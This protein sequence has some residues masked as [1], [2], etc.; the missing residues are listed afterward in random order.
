LVL[1]NQRRLDK[2]NVEVF[3][4]LAALSPSQKKRGRGLEVDRDKVGRE[5]KL[6]AHHTS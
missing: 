4:D 6:T 5:D 2:F 3:S 1:A